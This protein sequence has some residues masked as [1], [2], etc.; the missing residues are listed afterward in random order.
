M[1]GHCMALGVLKLFR[2]FMNDLFDEMPWTARGWIPI[3]RSGWDEY[4]NGE[5]EVR[6]GKGEY[7]RGPV[8][9]RVEEE[10]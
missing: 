6:M 4:V 3:L 1:L 5:R 2:S 10:L 8:E 7:E 9:E